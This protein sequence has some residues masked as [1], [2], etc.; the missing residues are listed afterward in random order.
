MIYFGQRPRRYPFLDRPARVT[1]YDANTEKEGKNTWWRFFVEGAKENDDREGWFWIT[2]KDCNTPGDLLNHLVVISGGEHSAKI[3]GDWSQQQQGEVNV[4]GKIY[5][6]IVVR[7][8]QVPAGEGLSTAVPQSDIIHETG[9]F[10]APD[11]GTAKGIIIA[12]A[13]KVNPD[14][15]FSSQV[16]QLEVKVLPVA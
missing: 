6:G 14:L 10:I 11:E 3:F 4:N 8:K 7:T 16:E 13:L 9:N 2:R 12:A 15:N 5:R 1:G